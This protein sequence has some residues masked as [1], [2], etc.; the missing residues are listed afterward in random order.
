M[1]LDLILIRGHVAGGVLIGGEEI[2]IAELVLIFRVLLVIFQEDQVALLL[3]V[4]VPRVLPTSH[5]QNS[6]DKLDRSNNTLPDGF[7]AVHQFRCYLSQSYITECTDTLD[8]VLLILLK[9]NGVK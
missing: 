5:S 6:Q 3:N 4:N 2:Q 7:F 1:I 8:L 9:T